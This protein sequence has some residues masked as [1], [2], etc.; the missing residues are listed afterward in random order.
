MKDPFSDKSDS[1][2]NIATGVALHNDVAEQLVTSAEKGQEQMKSFIPQRLN[3]NAVSFWNAIPSLKIKT[4]SSTRKRSTIKGSTDK[5]VAITEDR[6][7]FGRLLIVANTQQVNL[8]EILCFEDHQ[9][10]P[11]PDTAKRRD[12]GATAV[13]LSDFANSLP[14]LR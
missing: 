8:R 10:R 3:S 11:V 4:F 7:L 1:L 6:D 12:C 9:E 5:L 13:L 14:P 2:S